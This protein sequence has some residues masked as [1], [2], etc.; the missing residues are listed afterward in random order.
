LS[1]ARAAG[2]TPVL[3]RTDLRDVYDPQRS[4]V[5]AWNGEVIDTIGE[6]A[7]LIERLSGEKN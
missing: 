1:G 3:R 5:A 7:Y 4:D 2:L 6:L